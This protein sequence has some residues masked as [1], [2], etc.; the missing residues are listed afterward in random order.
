MLKVIVEK[1]IRE[2]LG[3]VKFV[4][5][6]GACAVLILLSFYIGAANHKANV[7]QYNA[8]KAENTR[9]MEGLTSWMS[10]EQHRIFLPPQPL[11]ALV[12]GSSNDVGRTIDVHRRSELAAVDSKFNED[13]IYAVFR[14]LD[15]TFIFQIV[16]SLFAIMLGYD[17]ICGEKERGTLRLSFANPVPRATYILGKLLGS[18]ITLV[19]ALLIAILLS[20]LILPLLGVSLTGDEWIRL[21]AII[22]T[23]LLYFGVFLTLSVFVSSRTHRTSSAFLAL[24]V[25]WVV[26][27][28]IVP[29]SATLLAGRAVDVPSIDELAAQKTSFSRQLWTEYRDAMGSFSAPKDI[30]PHDM[31]THFNKFMDSLSTEREAKMKV[32]SDRL[33]E[34]R[35]NRQVVQQKFAFNVAR[36]SPAASMNLAAANLAGTSIGLKNRFH[37]TAMEYRKV[38]GDFIRE[39][40]GMNLGGGMIYVEINDDGEKPDPIDPSEL[41]V[42]TYSPKPLMASFSAAFVDIGILALF[43]LIFFVGAFVSFIRYD[44]R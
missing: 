21:A 31:M 17:A 12:T 18:F 37:E 7:E 16:L 6:F 10:L 29:R 25:I 9:Q 44:V 39:K 11:A 33:N 26:S 35:F 14:F 22:G 23:G 42:Y 30:D 36:V 41:P 40:T 8:A 38:F 27:V 5:T 24:L 1:E 28:L 3:S 34:D 13:P 19:T 2:I 4:I 43:N 20:C 32:F 15:L